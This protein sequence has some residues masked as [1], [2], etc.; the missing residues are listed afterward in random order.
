MPDPE[1]KRLLAL[2]G[3]GIRG[4]FSLEI[5]ARIEAQLREKTG[6]PKLVLADHFIISPGRTRVSSL[7]PVC[8]GV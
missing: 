5:L 7:P 6:N 1:I 4:T 3:G 8:L 2:D